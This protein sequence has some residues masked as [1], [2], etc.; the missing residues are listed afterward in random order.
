LLSIGLVVAI[1]MIIY[2]G[3]LGWLNLPLWQR[4]LMHAP[5]AFLVAGVGFLALNV[6]AWKNHW[7]PR[8]EKIYFL[9][10]GLASVAVLLLLAQWQLIG[11]GLA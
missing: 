8:G 11:L 4:L 9:T 6:P 2:S 10:F 3:F 5:F 1:P 7:W